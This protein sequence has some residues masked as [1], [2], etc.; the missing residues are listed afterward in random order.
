MRR[1]LV[2]YV[3]LLTLY[4]PFIVI[5]AIAQTATQATAKSPVPQQQTQ[6]TAKAPANPQQTA[7]AATAAT[8]AAVGSK[9]AKTFKEEEL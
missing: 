7:S 8:P 2:A 4:A 6:T 3:L 9:P 1:K 5:D